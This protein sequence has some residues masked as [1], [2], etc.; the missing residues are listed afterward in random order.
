MATESTRSDLPWEARR[1]RCWCV[2]VVGTSRTSSP[3][4]SRSLDSVAP[5]LSEHSIPITRSGPRSPTHR[6][7]A[8][9]P[10]GS[11]ENS[12][13]PTTRPS[14][15]TAAT[16][17]E[18]FEGSTPIATS[19][20]AS[21]HRPTYDGGWRRTSRRWV[22]IQP[23]IKSLPPARSRP[24][25]RSGQ[26]S[27]AFVAATCGFGVTSG[28]SRE[29]SPMRGTHRGISYACGYVLQSVGREEISSTNRIALSKTT[30]GEWAAR[31]MLTK[32]NLKP[33][34]RAGYDSLLRMHVLPT[35]GRVQLKGVDP[36]S[37]REW[38][39][40]LTGRGLSSSRVRQAYRVSPRR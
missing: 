36:M 24:E 25:G 5:K 21:F 28:R 1:R 10:R 29:L 12:A 20:L 37:V 13:V 9:C 27:A 2:N 15:S 38:L 4:R 6:S 26:R 35:F 16:A 14:G 34:T 39:S 3:D 30:I 17:S 18:L 7:R 40:G 33:K 8:R 19:T 31:W 11:L 32:S 22:E 23:S